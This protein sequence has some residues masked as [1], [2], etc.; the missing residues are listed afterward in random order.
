MAVIVWLILYSLFR[1]AA[2]ILAHVA[3]LRFTFT[4]THARR[5]AHRSV[6]AGERIKININAECVQTQQLFSIQTSAVNNARVKWLVWLNVNFHHYECV[7]EKECN[8][9]TDKRRKYSGVLTINQLQLEQSVLH[10]KRNIEFSLW[11]CFQCS[12][13]IHIE[14]HIKIEQRI[15]FEMITMLPI[16]LG[17]DFLSFYFLLTMFVAISGWSGFVFSWHEK[18]H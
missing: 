8:N 11:L 9:L 18:R 4:H 17:F 16:L 15:Q 12:V 7:C 13:C 3:C 6:R 2:E 5:H 10:Q 1:Y 14:V